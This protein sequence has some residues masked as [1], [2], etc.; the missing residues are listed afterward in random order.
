MI[1][2]TNKYNQSVSEGEIEKKI[3]RQRRCFLMTPLKS[4]AVFESKRGTIKGKKWLPVKCNVVSA[5]RLLV[6]RCLSYSF[7]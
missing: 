5:A 3:L 4:S 6:S 7:I 2:N 1:I